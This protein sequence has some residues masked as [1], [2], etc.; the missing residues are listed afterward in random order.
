MCTV[1]PRAGTCPAPPPVGPGRKAWGGPALSCRAL[2]AIALAACAAGAV[3]DCLVVYGNGRNLGDARDNA[4]WDAL[5]AQFNAAVVARLRAADLR[6]EPLVFRVGVDLA[7][8]SRTLMETAQRDGCQRVVDTTVFA[9]YGEPATL[10]VRLR[11]HPLL[12]AHGPRLP[13]AQPRI[14]EPLYTGQREYELNERALARL[15]L[16]ALAAELVEDYL[17]AR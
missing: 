4:H 16:D 9:N 3:A 7:A 8:A 1:E 6:A 15:K 13:G 17:A 11:V 10:V 12:G 5:N 14:G 2:L